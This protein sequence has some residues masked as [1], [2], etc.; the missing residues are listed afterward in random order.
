M[1]YNGQWGTVCDN[2]WNFNDAK[3]IGSQLGY[4]PPIAFRDGAYYGQGSGQIWLHYLSCTGNKL[5]IEGCLHSICGI[6]S[7]YHMKN[8][9]L[10]CVNSNGM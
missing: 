8:S 5:T 6:Q 1:Y 4:G 10:Q 3:V 2:E 7:Y 9:C